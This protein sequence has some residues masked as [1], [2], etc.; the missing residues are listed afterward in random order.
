MGN[1]DP[2]ICAKT[3]TNEM[4]VALMSAGNI[5]VPTEMAC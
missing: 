3:N 2:P 4:A 5:L 1:S